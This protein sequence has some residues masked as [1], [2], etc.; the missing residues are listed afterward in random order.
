MVKL[1]ESN[2]NLRFRN[3]GKPKQYES[4]LRKS[5]VGQICQFYL[6]MVISD[7]L[8]KSVPTRF[9]SANPRNHRPLY[10]NSQ[11]APLNLGG[12]FCSY[13]EVTAVATQKFPWTLPI[14]TSTVSWNNGTFLC[15]PLFSRYS[16]KAG[17]PWVPRNLSVLPRNRQVPAQLSPKMPEAIVETCIQ[18]RQK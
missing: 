12:G 10:P 18:V 1:M 5:E 9:C 13:L 3:M 14:K 6:R 8:S 16:L 2:S 17:P 7:F 4:C 11:P 15:F